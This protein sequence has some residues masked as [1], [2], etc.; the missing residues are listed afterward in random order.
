MLKELENTVVLIK[1]R[2]EFNQ[3]ME[4]FGK[5]GWRWCTGAVADKHKTI[6]PD[7][8]KHDQF[9]VVASDDFYWRG[10]GDVGGSKLFGQPKVISLSEFKKIQGLEPRPF[11]VG[12]RVK[13]IKERDN[14]VAPGTIVT[15]DRI[16]SEPG[17]FMDKNGQPFN[18]T[19]DQ[20]ELLSP[21]EEKEE[22]EKEPIVLKDWYTERIDSLHREAFPPLRVTYHDW[23]GGINFEPQKST[24]KSM[25]KGIMSY[26][27]DIPNKLK[28]VL[29]PGLQARY[30]LQH[31]L[32]DMEMTA[33]G[34]NF[35]LNFLEEKY[36]KE[37]GERAIAEVKRL[38][39][40][41]K[42]D[43]EE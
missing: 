31:I 8:F 17:W 39:K 3:L 11:Q 2:S 25:K 34:K 5:Q 14:I 37:L 20:L 23:S 18:S 38:K 29:N 6:E 1:S 15:V 30:Q 21:C 12:D 43:C 41:K 26:L 32:D 27:R 42:S 16:G 13:V 4:I 36:E 35:L 33:E 7:P 19:C 24:V 22:Q 9:W 28:R 40:L 10:V